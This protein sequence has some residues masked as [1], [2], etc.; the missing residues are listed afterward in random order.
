MSL[1]SSSSSSLEQG[2]Y[3]AL[4]VSEHPSVET[5]T[6]MYAA[7]LTH[8]SAA[9]KEVSTNLIWRRDGECTT[10]GGGMLR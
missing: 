2:S 1:S 3:L 9:V 4:M 10:V 7:A 8:D 6:A 5:P